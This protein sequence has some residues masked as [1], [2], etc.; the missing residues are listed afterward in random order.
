M[1]PTVSIL[2]QDDL[3]LDFTQAMA[4]LSVVLIIV[5]TLLLVIGEGGL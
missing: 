1:K 4:G 5:I 2:A 3:R